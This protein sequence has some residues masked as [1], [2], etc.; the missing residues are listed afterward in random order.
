MSSN[1]IS[2]NLENHELIIFKS[3]I[4]ALPDEIKIKLS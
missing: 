3:P 4:T 1:K 2:L